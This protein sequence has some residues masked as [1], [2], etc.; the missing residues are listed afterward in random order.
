MGVV[1]TLVL[2]LAGVVSAVAAVAVHLRWWGLLLGVVAVLAVLMGLPTGWTT[3]L[4]YGVGFGLGIGRLAVTRPEG[5]IV[6]TGNAAGYAVLVLGVA[7]VVASV[8]TLPRPG[9]PRGHRSV[10]GPT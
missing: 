2:L 3:R 4:P 6:I 8:A 5:D 7:V 10:G 9:T 1:R